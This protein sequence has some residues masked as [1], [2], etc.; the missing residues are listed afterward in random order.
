MNKT[1]PPS[2]SSL[3]NMIRAR[4][5]ENESKWEEARALRKAE[6][7]HD[8]VAT[9]DLIIESNRKGDEYRRLTEGVAER[10]ER[11]ELN[12][13]QMTELLNEAHK[14]VYNH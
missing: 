8:H 2:D 3:N 10:W 7:Q 11:R 14:K 1:Y 4:K 13:Q 6:G 5:F 12:N 9:I